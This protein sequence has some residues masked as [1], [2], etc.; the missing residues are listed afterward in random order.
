MDDTTDTGLLRI[1]T[2]G[3]VTIQHDGA[4]VVGL[5][6]RKAEALLVYLVCNRRT[7]AREMLATLLWEELPQTSAL[8]NLSVV[9][10]S[11]RKQLA[12]FIVTTRHTVALNSESNVWLDASDLETQI[13]AWREQSPE[14]I[15]HSRDDA[16]Q[17]KAGLAVYKG[18]FLAGFHIRGSRSFEE[19]ALMEREGLQRL[20]IEGLDGLVDY[21]LNSGDCKPGLEQ[22]QRLLMIDP[23]REKTHRQLML[24][25]AR[26]GERTAALDQYQTCR[27]LLAQELA[28]EPARETT[29]LLERIRATASIP[30][31]AFPPQASPC[32]GRQAEIA[33]ITQRLAIPDCRLLTIVGMGGVGKTRLAIQVAT[34]QMG[35]F[36]DGVCFVPLAPVSSREFLV[37]AIAEALRFTFHGKDAPKKQLL[38]YLCEKELLILLDNFEHLLAGAHLLAQIIQIA[39]Q[40][41]LL[42]TSRERLA[43]REEWLYEIQGLHYPET[44][45]PTQDIADVE[46]VATAFGALQLFLHNATR[47]QADFAPSSE[48]GRFIMRICQLVEGM[49]LGIELAS[50]WIRTLP[51]QEIAQAIERNLGFLTTAWSNVPARHQSVRAVFDHSWKLLTSEERRLFRRL[52]VLEGGFH[53]QAAVQ[54]AG[55]SFTS[56]SSLVDKSL[57]QVTPA[58]PG[59]RESRY[60][61]HELLRQYGAELLESVPEEKAEVRQLHCLHFT[62]FLQQREKDMSAGEQKEALEAIGEEIENVRAAWHYAV[63]IGNNDAIQASFGS[64]FRFYLVRGWFQEGESAFGAAAAALGAIEAK[65][66]R[67][68][69]ILLGQ[70]LA[71]QGAFNTELSLL[72]RAE[73]L[74][75]KS[76]T[77]L[78]EHGAQAEAAFALSCR[79]SVFRN[80]G[81]Y[82]QARDLMQEGLTLHLENDNRLGAANVLNE[83]GSVAYRLS[84]YSEAKEYL[85]ASL[86]IRREYNDQQGIARCLMNLGAV[87]YRLGDYQEAWHLGSDSLK[88][89]EAIGDQWGV[90]ACSNNLGNVA[91]RQGELPTAEKLYQQSLA[92]K[93]GMGHRMSMATSLYNLGKIARR[94]EEYERSKRLY[95]EALTI[96][97]EIGDQWSQ[98]NALCGL[99]QVQVEMGLYDDARQNY[100]Q[101]LAIAREIGAEVL[102][103]AALVENAALLALEGERERAIEILAMIAERPSREQE[104]Q[105]RAEQLI[106][107]LGPQ[108]PAQDYKAAYNRGK[109]HS[110]EEVLGQLDWQE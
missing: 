88:L 7:L 64:L 92:I 46:E 55:A 10:T 24:L 74:L 9:L 22:A 67:G 73:E 37:H 83:L 86:D 25:L 58:R 57:L 62:S 95:E 98:S 39:P 29:A 90:A 26:T 30:Q 5:V 96:L 94:L 35:A 81:Q 53:R 66:D 50:A 105:D 61:L 17:L 6:S 32:I 91:E 33:Q 65:K 20:A 85:Q 4:L 75:Q 31:Y 100:H 70:L 36:L 89:C 63:R 93:R 102:V 44:L 18:D 59:Q 52:S 108:L 72:D 87:A 77:L 56:L 43:L 69:A 16:A 40:V 14:Q 19:W 104:I 101:S 51:C 42:V 68:Q 21:Y 28:V 41:K 13:T 54:V 45:P 79:G 49:P 110:L 3:G 76:I 80:R 1:E 82:E 78:N 15:I 107:E 71:R 27:D 38:D 99:G 97:R 109:A 48:E 103:E 84:H 34:E 2:L 60:N 8:A 23:L 11:L 12:P 106:A 47:V